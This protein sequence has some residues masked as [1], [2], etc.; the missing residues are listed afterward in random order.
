MGEI[1]GKD[2]KMISITFGALADK[3]AI[4]VPEL[5][6]KVAIH[7]QKDADAITRL[8][9]RGLLASHATT[10]A[11]KRLMKNIFASIRSKY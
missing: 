2:K 4:Q 10:Q 3:I 11:R 7:F 6:K 8:A 1:P 5:D 9:V